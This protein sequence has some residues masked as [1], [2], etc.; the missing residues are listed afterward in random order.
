MKRALSLKTTLEEMDISIEPEE[1]I[2][3]NRTK[4]VR[5]GV[6]FPESGCSLVNREFETLPNRPQDKFNV[7]QEDIDEFR[8]DIY[9][10]WKKHS[11]EE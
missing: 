7:R 10:Y 5:D 9:P 11:M 8:K 4:N 6:V 2:V 3:G 1:L